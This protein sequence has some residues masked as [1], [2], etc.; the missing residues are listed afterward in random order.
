MNVSQELTRLGEEVKSLKEV[1]PLNAGALTRHSVIA[2]WS[3]TIDRESPISTYSM[4]AAFEVIFTRT[5]GENKPP[6]VQFAYTLDPDETAG[7]HAG[8]YGIVVGM[9]EGSIT[10]K[11]I[12]GYSNWWPYGESQTTGQLNIEVNAFSLVE[13]TLAIRRVYS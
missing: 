1:Q 6:F 7:R 2:T 12:L 13:G 10:Y 5:D 4:L 11:I 3:G 8:S 9:D